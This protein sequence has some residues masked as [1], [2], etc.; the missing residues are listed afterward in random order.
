MRVECE[1]KLSGLT[2]TDEV[3]DAFGRLKSRKWHRICLACGTLWINISEQIAHCVA[4]AG[5]INNLHNISQTWEDDRGGDFNDGV[6]NSAND[7][8]NSL[9][10]NVELCADGDQ[11]VGNHRDNAGVESDSQ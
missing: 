2:E 11:A 1:D 4:W 6:Q 9:Q 5:W 3:E 8:E 7:G 10:D